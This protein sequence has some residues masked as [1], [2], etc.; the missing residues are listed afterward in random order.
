MPGE[1]QQVPL[2]C[3][4]VG[5]GP[6]GLMA[7][8]YLRRFHRRIE[9]V[10]DGR[11]RT[12][13]IDRSHNVPGFPGGIPGPELLERLR[14]QL[15]DARGGVAQ[16]TV[17]ALER[18]DEG[19]QVRAGGRLLRCAR[20][21]LATGVV[22]RWP[23]APGFDELRERGLLR[24]CP[25]CD[26]HEHTGRRIAVVGSGR[27]ARREALFLA[28][29]SRNVCLLGLEG[30]AQEEAED[31][32]LAAE[33]TARSVRLTE[34]PVCTAK[35]GGD[36]IELALADGSA[37][38]F[39]VVYAALGT[40]PRAELAIAVGAR[41]DAGGALEIDAHCRTSVPGLYAVGDVVSALDQIAVAVGHG[42]IA[43]TDVHNRC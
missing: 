13:F 16:G 8:I 26:G 5:A 32:A 9:L 40:R 19:W 14:S 23:Q 28:H 1:A 3:V 15:A 21:V 10:D 2:D 17:E 35:A 25:I 11:T 12:R 38:T 33:L 36:G 20:V 27:R 34:A 37:R 39:D 24:Q 4:V 41:C 31:A 22:D 7:A 43:A 29:F 18:V 6:A 42:A 30:D